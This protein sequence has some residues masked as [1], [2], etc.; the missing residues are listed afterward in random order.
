MEVRTKET[1]MEDKREQKRSPQQT[2]PNRKNNREDEIRQ[3][4]TTRT[5][6]IVPH[7]IHKD[8]GTHTNLERGISRK[9]SPKKNGR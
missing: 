7:V 3:D 4:G 6:H 9:K 1:A 2:K 8:N 5:I